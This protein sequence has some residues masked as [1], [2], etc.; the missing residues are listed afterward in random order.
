MDYKIFFLLIIL[1]MGYVFSDTTTT[2]TSSAPPTTFTTPD[3]C[4]DSDGWNVN[5]TGYIWGLHG[6]GGRAYNNSDTCKNSTAVNEGLCTGGGG[7]DASEPAN[8]TINCPEDA[9]CTEGRCVSSTNA[10]TT[11][12]TTSSAPPTTF[13]TP[14]SCHPSGNWSV[15]VSGYVW[16][17]YEG[18]AYNYSDTCKNETTVI[19]RVCIAS[20]NDTMPGNETINCPENTLCSDGRCAA[21][22]G[23]SQCVMPG[24]DHPCSQVTLQEVL[25]SI[26]DWVNGDIRLGEVIKLIMSWIDPVGNVPD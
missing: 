1:L 10:T 5:V 23:T 16:G 14:N 19:K 2:T 20:D 12:T 24:N 11:T 21:S 15:N 22:N 6:E 3:S 26:T 9:Y 17:I 8:Q 4:H 7:G 18:R 25:D 13:T